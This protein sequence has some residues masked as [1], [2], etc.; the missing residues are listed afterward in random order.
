MEADAKA[1]EKAREREL[2]EAE[3]RRDREERAAESER[4]RQ[5]RRRERQ[6]DNILSQVGREITRSIFG[7]RRR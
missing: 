3:R 5:S 4:Q 1:A 2:R 6:M 7:T